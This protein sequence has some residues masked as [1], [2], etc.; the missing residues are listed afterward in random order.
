[1]SL[2]AASIPDGAVLYDEAL[3]SA[4]SGTLFDPEHWRARGALAG[5]GSGRGAV[6]Y[7]IVDGVQWVLRRY[8]R[9]GLI[10]R[11][12]DESFVFLGAARTRSFRELQLLSTLYELGLPVPRPVAARYRRRGLLYTSDLITVRIDA[13]PLSSWLAEGPL[14]ERRWR[15]IGRMVACFHAECVWHADL[16]AHN[17]LLDDAGVPYLLDFD[18]GRLRRHGRWRERNLAR[19]ARSLRKIRPGTAAG[20][21]SDREWQWLLAGYA[22]APASSGTHAPLT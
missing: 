9:G 2:R 1:V 15:A 22:T 18:R 21:Y 13:R 14:D 16:T 10:G 7:L 8:R 17:I 4:P 12:I 11:W 20:S 3:V 19:L 5:S 6:W